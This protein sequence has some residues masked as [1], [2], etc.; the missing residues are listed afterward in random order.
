MTIVET[1]YGKVQGTSSE[2][3]HSFKG[4]PFA[5]PPVGERRWHAPEP[6]APWSGVRTA[7]DWGKQAWQQAT[8]DSG[9]LSFVFNSRNA[10]FRD[11]DC[12]QLNVWTP[13]VDG[14]ERPVL[15]WIHGGGFSGGTGVRRLTTARRSR[16]VAT[17]WWSPSTIVWVRSVF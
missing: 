7:T 13:A 6:P 17:W 5:A 9:M 3:L 14:A 1:Q 10:A 4:I 2:R 15:V 16:P 8:G 12:L 11:E